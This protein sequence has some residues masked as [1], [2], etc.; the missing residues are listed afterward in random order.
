MPERRGGWPGP[1]RPKVS[2]RLEQAEIDWID[3]LAVER[4]ENRSDTIRALL[5]LARPHVTPRGDLEVG[6]TVELHARGQLSTSQHEP[7]PCQLAHREPVMVT[8]FTYVEHVKF[9]HRAEAK[10]LGWTT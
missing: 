10:R 5:K 1:P 9:A 6:E 4:G 7:F 8:D 2:F 3:K